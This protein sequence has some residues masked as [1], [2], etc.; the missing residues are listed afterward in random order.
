[1]YTWSLF[2]TRILIMLTLG[3][4]LKLPFYLSYVTYIYHQALR[5]F[6]LKISLI[7]TSQDFPIVKCFD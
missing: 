5:L 7:L 3:L 2:S 1:M 4:F 6:P